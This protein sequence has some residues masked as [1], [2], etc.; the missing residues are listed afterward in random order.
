MTKWPIQKQTHRTT[1]KHV[2]HQGATDIQKKLVLLFFILFII[3]LNN[4]S[5]KC[6]VTALVRSMPFIGGLNQFKAIANLTLSQIFAKKLFS[7]ISI[8][9]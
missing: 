8:H 1:H 6:R 3:L 2:E 5:N 9:L 7:E 4:F